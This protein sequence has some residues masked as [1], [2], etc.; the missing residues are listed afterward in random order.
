M[1]AW[2]IAVVLLHQFG[3]TTMA[4]KYHGFATW[5]LWLGVVCVFSPI[6]TALAQHILGTYPSGGGPISLTASNADVEVS[7]LEFL[8]EN[9][10]LVPIP[11]LAGEQA[12]PTPFTFVLSNTSNN[13]TCLLYTSDAAD[14]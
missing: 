12:D 4:W 9:G 14:E 5:G 7:A 1:Q 13:V 11:S 6:E 2:S 10:D 3:E 8:S